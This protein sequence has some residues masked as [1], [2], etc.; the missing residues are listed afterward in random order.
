MNEITDYDFI[1]SYQH[2]PDDF[3]RHVKEALKYGWQP[4]GP[5]IL[6][7]D[8]RA[9]AMVKYEEKQNDKIN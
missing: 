1:C 4:Y 8:Y 9:Q 6:K 7:H 3:L 2:N 5:P